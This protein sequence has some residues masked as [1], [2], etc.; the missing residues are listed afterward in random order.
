MTTLQSLAKKI[1]SKNAGP[2]W[3]TF[4]FFCENCAD[5]TMVKRILEQN[6]VKISELYK[7]DPNLVLIFELANIL[8]VKLSIPRAVPQ[9]GPLDR[10]THSGQAFV[11][12]LGL[13]LQ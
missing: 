6:K 7:V 13:E 11:S 9:G 3:V 10:D 2:S 1:R 12:L 8:V 4:D 5:V